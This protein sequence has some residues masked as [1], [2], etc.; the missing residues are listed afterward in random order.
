MRELIVEELKKIIIN[1]NEY[2]PNTI[3]G[4]YLDF[5]GLVLDDC[6]TLEETIKF[7][8]LMF[9]GEDAQR[10]TLS[11]LIM[12]INNAHSLSMDDLK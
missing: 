7:A 11:W 4:L 8:K 1:S 10:I 2:K 9:F 12:A 5:D 3:A 6:K